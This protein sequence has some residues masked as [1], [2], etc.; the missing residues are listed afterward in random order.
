[1]TRPVTTGNFELDVSFDI[2]PFHDELFLILLQ[3]MPVPLDC[4]DPVRVTVCKSDDGINHYSDKISDGHGKLSN[5]LDQLNGKTRHELGCHAYSA[6]TAKQAGKKA[7]I[8]AQRQV[9]KAQPKNEISEKKLTLEDRLLFHQAKVKE[10]KSFFD[11]G[12]WSF[13]T[14]K[15]AIPSRTVQQNAP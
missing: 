15:E 4:L 14:T 5:K 12:V 1:M 6:M 3:H 7:K 2:M 9:R 10:L 11:N 8:H 13:Q